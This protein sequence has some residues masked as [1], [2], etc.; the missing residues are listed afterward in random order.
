MKTN[1]NTDQQ[2]PQGDVSNWAI[3]TGCLIY[4]FSCQSY[5]AGGSNTWYKGKTLWLINNCPHTHVCV[6]LSMRLR[7]VSLFCFTNKEPIY[8]AVHKLVDMCWWRRAR[9]YSRSCSSISYVI[10]EITNYNNDGKIAFWLQLIV[11]WSITLKMDPLL[12]TQH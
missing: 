5:F 3:V 10:Y 4:A 1:D 7:H 9:G 2:H 11:W 6:S 12:H 8:R